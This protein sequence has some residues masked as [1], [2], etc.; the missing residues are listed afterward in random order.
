MKKE[1]NMY[2]RGG[3]W[4]IELEAKEWLLKDILFDSARKVSMPVKIII[5]KAPNY[6][7]GGTTE[8]FPSRMNSGEAEKEIKMIEA[9]A[10][11]MADEA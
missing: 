8:L 7:R 6:A 5:N 3:Q 10:V 9:K 2:R 1:V 4:V 11:F